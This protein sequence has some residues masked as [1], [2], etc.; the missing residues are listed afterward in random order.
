MAVGVANALG[1][2]PSIICEVMSS[3]VL[4]SD[5]IGPL[6]PYSTRP[7]AGLLITVAMARSVATEVEVSMGRGPSERF[8]GSGMKGIWLV[9]DVNEKKLAMLEIPTSRT[10]ETLAIMLFALAGSAR[11]ID[12]ASEATAARIAVSRL[13]RA[14][15]VVDGPP[16]S[17]D[18]DGE[19]TGW[20]IVAV[21][22]RPGSNIPSKACDACTIEL[23]CCS[24][25]LPC[26]TL[27]LT[28]HML[29]VQGPPHVVLFTGSPAQLILQ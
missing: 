12:P 1:D 27:P 11:A 18:P 23:T 7:I 6:I 13:K 19:N 17:M 24:G 8:V 28:L 14:A 10:I 25:L 2:T 9:G 22:T 26:S 4:T 20:L 16:I 29:S 15:G 5:V 3:T 21:V